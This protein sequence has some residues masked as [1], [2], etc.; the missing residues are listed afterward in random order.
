MSFTTAK[1]FR[2]IDGVLTPFVMSRGVLKPVA[3]APLPGS[4]EAFLAATEQ[5]V[6]FQGSRGGGKTECLLMDFAQN[7]GVGMGPEYRGLFFRPTF[8]QL[9]EAWAIARK[10]FPKIWPDVRFNETLMTVTFPAGEV[11]TFRPVPNIEAFSDLQGKNF[12]WAGADELSL[13][14]DLKVFLLMLS[15][16]RSTHPLAPKPLH[17]RGATNCYGDARDAIL[18]FFKMLPVIQP[19][20]GPLIPEDDE[21]PARRVITGFFSE[22]LPLLHAQPN[23]AAQIA[24]S[25]GPGNDALRQAWLHSIWAAP[26][27]SFFAEVDF[28]DVRIKSFDPPSP[29]RIRISLDWGQTDPS[30]VLFCWPSKGE[31]I[32]FPDGTIRSTR[33]GDVYVL[34][35]VY[36]ASKP[37]QGIHLAPHQLAD[38]IKAVVERRAWNPEILRAFGNVAD[39]QIF[40]PSRNDSRASTADDLERAGIIFDRADKTRALGAAQ[41]LKML[42]GASPIDGVRETAGLFICE[43]CENLLRTLPNLRRDPNHVDDVDT[44]GEDHAYDS[45][46]Y[47]LRREGTGRPAMTTRRRY[48]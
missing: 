14:P 2:V 17:L 8:P 40:D 47:F 1:E 23:Y 16:L 33:K 20:V 27:T 5:I 3:W 12:Q 45:L 44:T 25:V 26:P 11:L 13:Y 46:R 38:R 15:V 41:V 31:D 42:M 29:G 34:E 7:V 19:T 18:S 30:C 37:N 36:T 10:L 39:F 43:N 35:E 24:A 21:G 6:L 32:T 48:G 4:Q 9:A 28:D 22:N